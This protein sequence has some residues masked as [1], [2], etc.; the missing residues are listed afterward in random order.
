MSAPNETIES[1]DSRRSVRFYHDKPVDEALVLEL[2]EAANRAPSG[3]NLQPWYFVVVNDG[4]LRERLRTA[5]M[6]QRQV[7]EAPVLIAFVS[8][9]DCWKEQFDQ[10]LELGRKAGSMPDELCRFYRK[11]VNMLFAIGPLGLFGLIKRL[12]LPLRRLFKPTPHAITSA[13]DARNYV[14]TQT[15]LSAATFMIA[16]RSVGLDT[17]PMEGFDESR[18]KKIL[19]IPTRMS[20]PLLIALGYASDTEEASRSVRLP[21]SEKVRINLFPKD[22]QKFPL[23]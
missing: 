4:D 13:A 16:A 17:S 1:I 10:I 8:D 21:L 7:T 14:K 22:E 3:F 2:L 23:S 12:A 15:M 5:A 19:K 6:N 18:V 20:V 9:P 11:N